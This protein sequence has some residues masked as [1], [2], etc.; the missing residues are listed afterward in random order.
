MSQQ[1]LASQ[2]FP[3]KPVRLIQFFDFRNWYLELIVIFCKINKSVH[4]P[5]QE[6]ELTFPE[7]V[8]LSHCWNLTLEVRSRLEAD[9]A[10][11][12]DVRLMKGLGRTIAP[13]CV[14]P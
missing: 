1:V 10:L 9:E 11:P 5:S 14:A 8:L 7:M 13:P 6:T 2:T 3:I 4:I 12:E